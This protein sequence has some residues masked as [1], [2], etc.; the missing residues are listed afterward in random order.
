MARMRWLQELLGSDTAVEAAQT[1]LCAKPTARLT[2]ATVL[3]AYAT[4]TGAAEGIAE[5][6]RE[7]L[8]D[9]GIHVQM[10]DFD[11]LSP[12]VLEDASQVLFITSTTF[13]GEPPEMAEDFHAQ[14]M[15]QPAALAHLHYA[16]LALGDRSYDFFCGFGHRLDDWLRDSGAQP[17]FN[18]IEVDDEDE[19]PIDHWLA[20]VKILA[21]AD[22]A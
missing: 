19:R 11:D 6:T 1:P 14:V 16:L 12:A 22:D 15:Q 5:E 18:L 2:S 8:E 4:Q 3:I 17:W 20:C 10:L 7:L 13:D 9:A 21:A